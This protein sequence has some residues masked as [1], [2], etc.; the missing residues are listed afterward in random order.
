M[1]KFPKLILVVAAIVCAVGCKK[2]FD[3]VDTDYDRL[4]PEWAFPVLNTSFKMTDFTAGLV[5][6]GLMV[7]NTDNSYSIQ[8]EG[9]FSQPIT[10]DIFPFLPIPPPYPM[11][12]KTT[13][14]PFLPAPSVLNTQKMTFRTGYLAWDMVSFEDDTKVT[15]KIPELK[16]P[17]G[18]PF[19]KTFTVFKQ[20]FR[21]L[22]DLTGMTL[23]PTNRTMSFIYEAFDKDGQPVTLKEGLYTLP[24]L[25]PKVF[26]GYTPAQ[27]FQVAD[28]DI[29]LDVF[30]KL[31]LKG[32]AAFNNPKIKVIYEN[33]YGLFT[34]I[35]PNVLEATTKDG[36]K[37]MLQSSLLTNGVN[38]ETPSLSQIG[39]TKTAFIEFNKSNSNVADVINNY[40][41]SFRMGW[42]ASIGDVNQEGF[43]TNTSSLRMKLAVELPL[44][45]VAKDFE[46]TSEEVVDLSGMEKVS[47]G[48]FKIITNNDLPFGMGFQAYFLDNNGGIIDSLSNTPF[49]PLKGAVINSNGT[50]ATASTETTYLKVDAAKLSRIKSSKK[51]RLRYLMTTSNDG[52]VPVRIYN[53]QGIDV[54]IGLKAGIKP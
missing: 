41:V 9:T 6:S 7:V 1:K 46:G 49:I 12:G 32:S 29:A 33:S 18:R 20:G 2:P 30:N 21:D 14:V 39:S 26:V 15:L 36:K 8:Y 53:Y 42:T 27:T 43:F 48:E 28:K 50:V 10:F 34:N 47:S 44:E 52:T 23:E 38:L 16:F 51:M 17:D 31:S 37:I 11:T 4:T 24:K 22:L 40:P 3:T 19:E 5:G 25:E 13:V 35:K 45:G 54:R